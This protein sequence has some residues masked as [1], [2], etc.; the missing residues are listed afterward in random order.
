MRCKACDKPLKQ[1]DLVVDEELCNKCFN[2]NGFPE[3]SLTE[4]D[5]EDLYDNS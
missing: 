3:T 4:E 2:Y 5:D 1:H